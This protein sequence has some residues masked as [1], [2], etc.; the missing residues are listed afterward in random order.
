MENRRIE[1]WFC[2]ECNAKTSFIKHKDSKYECSVCNTTYN[3]FS[4]LIDKQ[5]ERM[6]RNCE[7]AMNKNKQLGKGLV[8]GKV[9]YLPV[10]DGRAYYE[11]TKV[12]PRS[13]TIKFRE[14]IAVDDYMDMVLGDGG[15][16]PTSR[17]EH[18]VC[19][20]DGLQE[21]FLLK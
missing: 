17:I 16:F 7:E 4:D 8:A 18:L 21:I 3:K 1:Q 10:A 20:M 2:P 9:F 6:G 5:F 19:R 15:S 13:T 14:D 11:V 12:G